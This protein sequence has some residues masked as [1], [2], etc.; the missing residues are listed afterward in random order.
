MK[1]KIKTPALFL[2]FFSLFFMSQNV[3]A[4]NDITKTKIT[5]NE[6][7]KSISYILNNISNQSGLKFSYNPQIIDDKK[8]KI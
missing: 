3:Y 5:L 2:L 1:Y 6:K 8:V 4:Q 7:Q